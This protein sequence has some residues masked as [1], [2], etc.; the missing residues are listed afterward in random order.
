MLA[1]ASDQLA[2]A[3]HHALASAWI[4]S[5]WAGAH[6][7]PVAAAGTGAGQGAPDDHRGTGQKRRST[8]RPR[9]EPAEPRTRLLEG[10]AR[11]VSVKGY[12]ATTITDI[13]REARVSRRTFYEQFFDKPAL[14]MSL[15]EATSDRALRALRAAIDPARSLQDQLVPAYTAYFEALAANPALLQVVYVEILGLGRP[16]LA[17]RRRANEEVGRF[18][19]ELLNGDADKDAPVPRHTAVA[20]VGAINELVADS[21]ERGR[22]AELAELAPE[23]AR[24]TR[25]IASPAEQDF[26][27]GVLK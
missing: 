20:V 6:A 8:D 7:A 1:V 14:L 21:I 22:A 26:A 11:V 27:S 2:V 4:P 23:A 16:G 17:A 9:A 10:M 25:L 3:P 18:L 19:L 24:L 12:A 13:V 5:F 15:F